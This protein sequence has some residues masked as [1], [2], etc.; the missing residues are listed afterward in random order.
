MTTINEHWDDE[1]GNPA[2]GVS[3]GIGYTIS[4][5][6]GPL[7]HNPRNGAFI[8]EVLIALQERLSFFQEGRFPCPENE[9]ALAHLKSASAVMA[10]RKERRTLAGMQGFH[11]EHAFSLGDANDD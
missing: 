4:W 6:N 9:Q 8:E 10:A 1:H 5:Q 7:G 2:G 11:T 3:T